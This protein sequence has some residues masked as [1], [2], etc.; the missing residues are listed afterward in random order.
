[1]LPAA[2]SGLHWQL[3]TVLRQTK[4][5]QTTAGITRGLVVQAAALENCALCLSLLGLVLPPWLEHLAQV[6]QSVGATGPE[7][8]KHPSAQRW[9]CRN[10]HW[11]LSRLGKP[12]SHGLGTMSRINHWCPGLF[13]LEVSWVSGC[14][15]HLGF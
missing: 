2:A 8:S 3:V 9:E 14:Y 13:G 5:H 15:A 11:W 12:F 1:M 7:S 10:T 6:T 4:G